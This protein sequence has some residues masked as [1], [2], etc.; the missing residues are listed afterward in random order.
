MLLSSSSS[1]LSLDPY[2]DDLSSDPF[3]ESKSMQNERCSSP[4]LVISIPM[5]DGIVFACCYWM[6]SCPSLRLLADFIA[7]GFVEAVVASRAGLLGRVE[8]SNSGPMISFF[9]STVADTVIGD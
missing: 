6:G 1:S 4:L 8:P 2:H 9:S 5:D 3:I 7:V